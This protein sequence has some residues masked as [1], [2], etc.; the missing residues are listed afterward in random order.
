MVYVGVGM[1]INTISEKFTNWLPLRDC[2]SYDYE[3][4]KNKRSLF[5]PLS[6]RY[7][8]LKP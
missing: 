2:N 3:Q 8:K 6:P 7:K 5:Y 1:N 4:D